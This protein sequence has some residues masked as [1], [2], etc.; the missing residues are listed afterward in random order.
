MAKLVHE[1]NRIKV[2]GNPG[3]VM[4]LMAGIAALF[5]RNMGVD[6][7][8]VVKDIAETLEI[9]EEQGILKK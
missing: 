8:Q 6:Y 1:K 4:E 7:H 3:E 9:M 5:S 2:Q